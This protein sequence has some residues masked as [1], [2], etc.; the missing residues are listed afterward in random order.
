MS[1]S[2][3]ARKAGCCS[4]ASSA[5][6]RLDVGKNR[7]DRTGS[8]RKGGSVDLSVPLPLKKIESVNRLHE[9]LVQWRLADQALEMLA[10]RCAD[11]KPDSCLLKVVAVNGLYGTNLYAIPPMSMHAVGV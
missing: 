1:A 3:M 7:R 8:C 9:R 2:W 5:Q 6:S 4:N 11:F 10:A